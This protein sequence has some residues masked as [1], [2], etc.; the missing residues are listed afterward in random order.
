[1]KFTKCIKLRG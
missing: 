1:M